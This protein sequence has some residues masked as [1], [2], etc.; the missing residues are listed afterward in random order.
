MDLSIRVLSF[1]VVLCETR[2]WPGLLVNA[3][4]FLLEYGTRVSVLVASKRFQGELVLNTI[5][6]LAKGPDFVG[7][8]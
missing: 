5:Q 7:M 4:S 6:I 2:D 8:R 1:Q 3:L